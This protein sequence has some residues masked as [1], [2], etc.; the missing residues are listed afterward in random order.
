MAYVRHYATGVHFV[1]FQ[2][3]NPKGKERLVP[4]TVDGQIP[5][6]EKWFVSIFMVGLRV[7]SPP[8]PT[9]RRGPAAV[10]RP[11]PLHPLNP[12]NPKP[13]LNELETRNIFKPTLTF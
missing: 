10:P 12:H 4:V 1:W 2:N 6:V 7:P 5:P 13:T 11:W 3:G 9:P 8:N